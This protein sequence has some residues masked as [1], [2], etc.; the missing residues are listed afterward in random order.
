MSPPLR[1]LACL[2][3]LPPLYAGAQVDLTGSVSLQSEYRYRGQTPGGHGAVPQLTLNLDGAGGWYLGGFASAVTIGDLDGYKL[4]GYAGY[5]QRLR[6]GWSWELGCSH[7][8][9][10]QL[11]VNDFQECYGGLSGERFSSRL[12]YAPRYLGYPARVLYGEVNLFYPI[13]PSFNLIAHAGL[14]HSLSAGVW[15]GIPANSRYDARLGVS[16]PFGDWTLQVAREHGQDDG[17][18][19]RAYPVH[20]SKAWSMSATYSF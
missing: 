2:L 19:Y 18:R 5:A 12:Y 14:L 4:Q 6:S 8:G 9:Y 11:H 20:P 7:I 17:M 3:L 1:A 15:P 16:I 10:T 13:H